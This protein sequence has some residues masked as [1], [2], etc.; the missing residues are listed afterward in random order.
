MESIFGGDIDHLAAAIPARRENECI[1]FNAFGNVCRMEPSGLYLDDE[2][3]SGPKGIVITLYAL[4]ANMQAPIR[5]PLKAFKEFPD[6]MPYAGAFVTHTENILVPHVDKIKANQD[7][8][9]VLMD[10]NSAPAGTGGDAAFMVTPLPKISLCYII[11][12][13]D[14]DFPASVTC[15]Y[16]NNASQFMPMDG[17]ADVGEYTSRR[18]IEILE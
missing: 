12:D 14:E 6:S 15:L 1:I 5:E 17:L 4:S 9:L 18:I 2:P 3:E 13:A 11:Y 16:S 8:I 10:G 7:R